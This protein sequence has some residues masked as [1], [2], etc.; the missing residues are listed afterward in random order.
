MAISTGTQRGREEDTNSLLS[1]QHEIP[2][3]F[4]SPP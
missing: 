1:Q 2:E 4:S 3:A